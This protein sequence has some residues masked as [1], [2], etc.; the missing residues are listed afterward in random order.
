MPKQIFIWNSGSGKAKMVDAVRQ[1]VQAIGPTEWL[2][3]SRD[4]DLKQEIYRAVGE[5]CETVIAGGGD[6][7]LNAVVNAIMTLDPTQRPRL[8][9]VPLGTANDFAGTLAIPDDVEAAVDLIASQSLTC[10]ATRRAGAPEPNSRA[11]STSLTHETTADL[12]RV[13]PIDVVRISSHDFKLFYANMAA[14]GNCVRVSES[15]TDEIKATWGAFCYLRGALGVLADMKTFAIR[16]DCDGEIIECDSWGVLVANGKTNAG[17]IPVAP[18]ASPADGLL[19]VII[20][21]EGTMMD[22][23]E[24]VSKTLLTSFLDSDKVMF[25][26]VKKLSLIS[27]PDMRYTLDGEIIDQEPV[28]FEVVPGAINMIVGTEFGLV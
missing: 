26:Q 8:A 11:G 13:V 25:R 5:G 23:V 21:R 4:V 27:N 10:R 7:T 20:I 1:R 15:L 17:R 19:D 28:N 24:I 3:L 6:G 2:E 12:G 14:G 16:A 9:I 18:Q 22:M